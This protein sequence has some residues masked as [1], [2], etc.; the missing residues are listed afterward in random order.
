MIQRL[1][2]YLSW[3]C[4]TFLVTLILLSTLKLGVNGESLL[5]LGFPAFFWVL[6]IVCA[7]ANSWWLLDDNNL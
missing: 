2:T 3:Y 1:K 7:V 4:I 5:E 6:V